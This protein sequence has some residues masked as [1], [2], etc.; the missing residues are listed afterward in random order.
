[1][2]VVITDLVDTQR[3]PR[4]N[5]GERDSHC[6]NLNAVVGLLEVAGLGGG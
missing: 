5:H 1:V 6:R 3:T 4:R 2:G